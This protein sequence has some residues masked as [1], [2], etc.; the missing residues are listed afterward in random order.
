MILLLM[1]AG[2]FA[3]ILINV[4]IAVAL[5][6][7]AVIAMLA[8]QGPDILPNV[9]LVMF[10]GATPINLGSL[11]ALARGGRLSVRA[12]FARSAEIPDGPVDVSIQV[13]LLVR[14]GSEFKHVRNASVLSSKHCI[15]RSSF[16]N[17]RG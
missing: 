10:D 8:S 9:A 12:G 7:V 2:L 14:T 11:R 16:E 15:R 3:L 5:G 17:S 1:I 6:V 13:D 4:P